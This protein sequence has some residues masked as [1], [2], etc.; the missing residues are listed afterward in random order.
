MPGISL[1][2]SKGGTV[3]PNGKSRPQKQI[4]RY[5]EIA[6]DIRL[7]IKTGEWPPE[8]PVPSAAALCDQYGV[9]MSVTKKALDLL[10]SERRVYGVFGVGTFVADRPSRVRIANERQL[11]SPE[12]PFGDETNQSSEV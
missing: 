6:A 9:S 4:P 10:K 5:M 2:W 11:R 3:A 12:V 8:H 7:K 1:V